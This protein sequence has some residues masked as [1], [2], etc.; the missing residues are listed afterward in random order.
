MPAITRNQRKNVIAAKPAVIPVSQS[1]ALQN[2]NNCVCGSF[3]NK[4]KGLLLKCEMEVSK[5][6]KMKVALEIY[7]LIN[8]E[9]Y[10]L[11]KNDAGV[12]IWIKFL[13]IVFDK[14]IYFEKEYHTGSWNEIDKKLVETFQNELGKAKIFVVNTIKNYN[15]GILT[16]VVVKT[17]EKIASLECQRP[18][19]PRRNIPRVDYTGMDTIEPESEFDGIPDIWADETIQ[20]DPDYEFE[21]QQPRWAKIH[22]E[23]S[24]EEK[25]ELKNHLTQLVDN[26]RVRRIVSQ[27]NYTGMDMNYDDKGVIHIAK[28]RFED[29]KVKYIWQ[30]YSLSK[31]N[32]I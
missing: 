26:N 18:Q 15:S 17:K 9:L 21:E 19:R 24:A 32:E 25:F 20:E 11:I 29:G 23:L 6:N 7:K 12:A 5:E 30:S 16:D 3:H 31:A 28:K 8:K 2:F 27:V 4:I 13:C 10:E 1:P 14:I 22:P